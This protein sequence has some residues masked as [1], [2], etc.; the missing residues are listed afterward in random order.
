MVHKS[1]NPIKLLAMPLV[2]YRLHDSNNVLVFNNS[3]S[4]I[5]VIKRYQ[6]HIPQKQLNKLYGKTYA[7]LGS[8]A[9]IEKPVESRKYHVKSMKY[10]GNYFKLGLLIVISFFPS[11]IRKVILNL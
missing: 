10:T 2:Y 11:P 3:K 9:L 7:N 6:K 5:N 1:G 4:S 8:L